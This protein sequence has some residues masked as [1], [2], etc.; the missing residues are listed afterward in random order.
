MVGQLGKPLLHRAIGTLVS[1]VSKNNIGK[2]GA[3]LPPKANT[4]KKDTPIPDKTIAKQSNMVGSLLI[5]TLNR[6]NTNQTSVITNESIDKDEIASLLN[7]AN[8]LPSP[9]KKT[10]NPQAKSRSRQKIAKKQGSGKLPNQSSKKLPGKHIFPVMFSPDKLQS[11]TGLASINNRPT[12]DARSSGKKSYDGSEGKRMSDGALSSHFEC[13]QS[14][15]SEKTTQKLS[16]LQRLCSRTEIK[17]SEDIAKL[18]YE[19][20]NW[21][22]E[23]PR[24]A[25]APLVNLE[26][27]DSFMDGLDKPEQDSTVDLKMSFLL[28]SM[29]ES[30]FLKESNL[31][32]LRDSVG[33]NILNGL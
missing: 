21:N 24:L 7:S 26:L 13:E 22:Q 4:R 1:S 3:P 27:R 16:I 2:S 30:T 11:A 9:E 33:A 32:S 15:Q 31:F 25:P 12:D 17:S 10:E 14:P 8:V 18:E 20:P 23:D 19:E 29:N 28:N 6:Q 5:S